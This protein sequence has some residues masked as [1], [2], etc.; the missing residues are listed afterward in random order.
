MDGRPTAAVPALSGG[1]A[2]ELNAYV[3]GGGGLNGGSGG[4]AT[5]VSA[6]SAGN[7]QKGVKRSL[8]GNPVGVPNQLPGF[9]G[10]VIDA[11]APIKAPKLRNGNLN[12]ETSNVR[13]PY[14]RVTP[15]EFLSSFQGR[16][17][18]G[19]VVFVHKY[20]P[21]FVSSRPDLHSAN[22]AT[23]GVNTTSRV[24]GLDGLN[25]LLMGSNPEGWKLGMNVMWLNAPNQ[26][27]MSPADVTEG[28][29]T[30]KF[31]LSVLD[32]YRLDG[33]VI[34][35]DEP[36]TFISSGA[37]DNCLF[38]IAI[39][40]PTPVNNGYLLY[41]GTRDPNDRPDLYNPLT[42]VTNA[43]TVE[44]HARGS[45]EAGQHLDS[46]GPHRG[47]PGRV[48]SP[49]LPAGKLDFVANFCGTY[50]V[51]P[52]QMFDR[53][54]E[55]LNTLYL[56]LRAYE[57]SF[58]AKMLV[59]DKSGK[60]V[61]DSPA[62][63]QKA[64]MVFFQYMP[65]SS[66]TAE[67]I[68][69]VTRK[70]LEQVRASSPA[71]A[72]ATVADL[73]ALQQNDPEGYASERAAAA[74]SVSS[75]LFKRSS[76]NDVNAPFDNRMFDA[77]RT[78]D[79]Q[80]FVGAWHVGRVLDTKAARHD[81]YAGGP[82]DTAFSCT[83]DV[84]LSWRSALPYDGGVGVRDV[85]E[86]RAPYWG[87]TV[88]EKAGQQSGL[89]LTNNAQPSMRSVLGDEFGRLV[90]E[91]GTYCADDKGKRPVNEVAFLRARQE[92]EV[93][94][95]R[96]QVAYVSKLDNLPPVAVGSEDE[97][98]YKSALDALKVLG[99]TQL[100]IVRGIYTESPK[101]N[102]SSTTLADYGK[103]TNAALEE[104]MDYV[105]QNI[106]VGGSAKA[107]KARAGLAETFEQALGAELTEALGK[108][109]ANN[110]LKVEKE[111]E[112][113][114]LGA[115]T[116]P[117]FDNKF[118]VG[119]A[120][121]EDPRFA[122]KP[123][124]KEVMILLFTRDTLV[125][126]AVSKLL[127]K[128]VDDFYASLPTT[129]LSAPFEAALDAA[130]QIKLRAIEASAQDHI[131]CFLE[132]QP[133]P[134]KAAGKARAAPAPTGAK[135]SGVPKARGKTPPKSRSVAVAPPAGAAGV[136]STPLVPTASPA[137]PS[138]LVEAAAAS[139]VPRRR[140]R[141]GGESSTTNSVFETMFAASPTAAVPEE[142]A[143]PTPSS[144][145]DQPAP[146]PRTFRRIQR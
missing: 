127:K 95:A 129:A 55:I 25:R 109:D 44:T 36:G 20:P 41:E 102:K 21:G 3:G 61:F 24:V 15:L 48:G 49:W 99:K 134:P 81:P 17:S 2:S 14:N 98:A 78:K 85:P 31:K 52:S 139:A 143:S 100:D 73:W 90:T 128:R 32:E 107:Q 124:L 40:G 57:L 84:G 108:R 80:S 38:N 64:C 145:S 91:A 50:S 35:N 30:A 117:L 119:S 68:H 13:I 1:N 103:A 69:Q 104:Y 121:I 72:N 58:E 140:V 136:S 137:S 132:F 88:R 53:R 79:L 29:N 142:P 113:Q 39:Q 76:L 118:S 43:R 87:A 86:D 62:E 19:D 51:Y 93:E 23:L 125:F 101:F 63:A 67:V 141:E 16:L 33:V 26:V 56:G 9:R 60:P 97:A 75:A 114:T 122:S 37:R 120:V 22:Q 11:G 94:K 111:L 47:V 116:Q 77:I 71:L 92:K 96:A 112:M 65:F 135:P 34:S 8:Q 7:P 27:P 133:P 106:P 5:P 70:H 144:G 12:N 83:V 42:G 66:R 123:E 110:I 45:A 74:K 4:G 10:R 105:Q 82:R 115:M 28:G 131:V 130:H 138:P 126:N 46:G 89:T 6:V 59:T 146:G 18:P 54:I